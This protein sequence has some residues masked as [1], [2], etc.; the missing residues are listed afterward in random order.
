MG[1]LKPVT[2]FEAGLTGDEQIRIALAEM[3]RLGGRARTSDLYAALDRVLN[4]RDLTLS[5][6][7]KDSLRFFI[8]RNA[9]RAGY[10]H[11][12][13]ENDPGWRI[14]EAG[15]EAA[16][17][18]TTETAVDVDSGS[19]QE[20]PSNTARGEAFELY[21]ARV[22]K[23]L[24]PYYAWIHQGRD[25]HNE[26]GLDFLGRR[27]VLAPG[28]PTVI[29]VQVKFHRSGNAPTE[30]EWLKFLAGCFARRADSAVFVT[31]GR[32]TSEQRREAQEAGVILWEG[33]DE[34]TRIAS[35]YGIEA[36][37]LFDDDQGAPT[38]D[39]GERVR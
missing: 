28:E 10:V 39:V 8:N 26:R 23:A 29:A 34:V 32:V 37:D 31:T 12:H 4:H 13:D 11:P 7:G 17:A 21:M 38:L 5:R 1:I 24:H 36:F 16:D 30:R 20:V 14:T 35:M 19:E 15:R 27:I 3:L 18:P 6:Q 2:G 22:L 9:V 25:K 33:R